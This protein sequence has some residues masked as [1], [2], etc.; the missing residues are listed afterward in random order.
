MS[1]RLSYCEK[2]GGPLLLVEH[3]C[4][5]YLKAALVSDLRD[6]VTALKAKL[7]RYEGSGH[8]SLAALGEAFDKVDRL[9][10]ELEAADSLAKML[11]SEI[12]RKD[13]EIVSLKG[14]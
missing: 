8:G 11:G 3:D 1:E 4:T 10:L 5:P 6:E 9:Y 12:T 2:C 14:G 7:K 13:S